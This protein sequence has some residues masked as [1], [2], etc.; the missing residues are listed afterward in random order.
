[1]TLLNGVHQRNWEKYAARLASILEAQAHIKPSIHTTS[2]VTS[3]LD[4]HAECK[5]S[6]K[7]ELLQKG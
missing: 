4:D 7:C 3:S 2:V 5:L 1:M 6:F